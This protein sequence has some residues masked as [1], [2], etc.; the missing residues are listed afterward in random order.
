MP[1][2]ETEVK[3]EVLPFVVANDVNVVK[4][5]IF[6]ISEGCNAPS[7]GEVIGEA[8]SSPP[9]SLEVGEEGSGIGSVEGTLEDVAKDKLEDASRRSSKTELSASGDEEGE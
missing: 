4:E 2:A 7:E 5:V 6:S 8:I 9:M 1:S 3:R